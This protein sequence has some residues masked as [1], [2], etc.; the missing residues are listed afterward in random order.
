MLSDIPVSWFGAI[1]ATLTTVCWLPQAV[2]LIRHKNTQAISLPTNLIFFAGLF[3]WLVY[4]IAIGDWPLIAAN[5]VS[6]VLTT[7][8]V[9][10]KLRYG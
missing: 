10:M 4:G 8:I 1:G 7:I 5:G 6:I 2:R 9:A 3:F